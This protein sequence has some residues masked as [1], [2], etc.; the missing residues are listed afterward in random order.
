MNVIAWDRTLFN[1][2]VKGLE[3]GQDFVLRYLWFKQ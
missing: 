2:G 1:S 3:A